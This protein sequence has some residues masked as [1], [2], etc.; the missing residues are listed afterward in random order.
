MEMKDQRLLQSSLINVIASFGF[1]KK[2]QIEFWI[3]IL[4]TLTF[5]PLF[6]KKKR[7]NIYECQSV[8]FFT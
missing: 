1:F 4:Y 3:R 2:E 6:I 7:N 5:L 8:L